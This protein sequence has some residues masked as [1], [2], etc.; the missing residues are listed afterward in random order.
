[1]GKC[2]ERLVLLATV[3]SAMIAV[4]RVLKTVELTTYQRQ[5]LE[6]ALHYLNY[7]YAEKKADK[8]V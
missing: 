2:V 3:Y 8:G 5:R 7:I 1:M 4:D 6:D